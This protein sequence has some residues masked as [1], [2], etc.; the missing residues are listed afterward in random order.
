MNEVEKAYLAAIVDG[1][2]CI[3]ITNSA[4][5]SHQLVLVV[6]MNSKEVIDH[7]ARIMGCN[8]RQGRTTSAGNES[9]QVSASGNKAKAII[10]E[11]KPYLVGKVK[12]AE[13][14]L[15]FPVHKHGT[16]LA[17]TNEMVRTRNI[18]MHG[19][20]AYNN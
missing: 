2:G 3:T 10:S 18:I 7:I 1:E 11:I 6:N 16:P 12:Q 4:G 17:I 15:L 14:A 5:R 8:I 13:L 20:R 19:I 9:Y